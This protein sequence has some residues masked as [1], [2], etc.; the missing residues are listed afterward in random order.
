MNRIIAIKAR[1]TYGLRILLVTG[2]GTSVT[3]SEAALLNLAD[4]PPYLITAVEP[5]V[6]LTFDDS[7]SMNWSYL[8]DTVSGLSN[9]NR[10][11]SSEINKVYFDPNIVYDTPVMEDGVTLLNAASPT[12]FT[13]AY[14]NGFAGGTRDNLATNYRPSWNSL[15]PSV[16]CN[17]AG[18]PGAA[19]YYTYNTVCGNVNSDACYTLVRPIPAAQQQNFAN[20]YS[21]YRNRNSMAKSAAGRAFA[22]FG[23]NVRVAGHHLDGSGGSTGSGALKFPGTF[24]AG[25]LKPFTGTNRTD[26][27]TSLYDSPASS[28]TPLR[29]AM[30]RA[31][32]YLMTDDPYLDTPGTAFNATTNPERSCRQNFHVFMTDGYWNSPTGPIPGSGTPG[33]IVTGNQ[34]DTAQTLPPPD[35]VSYTAGRAPYSDAWSGTLADAAFYYWATDLRSGLTNNVPTH[36]TVG[37]PATDYWNPVN[38]PANWQHMENFTIGLGIPGT[39]TKDTAT[40]N[41]LV[42]G[43]TAWPDPITNSLG[44]RIDD[45]W[46]AA[47]NSRGQYFSASN[48]T[49][50]VTAFTEV[51]NNVADRISSSSS[52]A[53]NSGSLTGSNFAYQARFDSSNWTGQLLAYPI[54][55]S[56]GVLSTTASWDAAV[57]LNG[58]HYDT[59]RQII[60]YKPSTRAGIP[61]RTGSLDTS[62]STA[63]NYNPITATTDTQGSA[64]LNYL[65]GDASNEG[66]GNNY[67]VRNRLCGLVACPPGTNTGVLGDIIN[68]GPLY[69]GPPPFDYPTSLE[70]PSYPAF[71]DLA[72]NKNRTPIIYAGANDGML[73]GFNASTGLEMFAYVPDKV[74]N[75][76]SRLAHTPYTHKYFVDGGTM[77]G[78]VVIGGVWRSILV[79]TLRKGGQGIFAIDITDPSSFTEANASNLVLWEFTDANDADLGYTYSEPSIVRMHN[80]KWAVI[81]G[82]GYN[83]SEADGM[84]STTGR[85]VLYI[86]VVSDYTSAGGWILGTNYFK[87]TTG[88]GSVTTPNGLASP[89]AVDN[90]GDY[91]VDQ[92]YAGDLQGNMWRFDVT[93]STASTWDNPGNRKLVY[94]AGSQQPITVRPRIRKHPAGQP[95]N[96]VY[97]GT[98]KYLETSDSSIV[99]ATTQTFYGVW[100]ESGVA[101]PV[102]TNLLEQTVLGSSTAQFRVTSNNPMIWR[103]GS[104]VPSPSYIGWYLDLPT[105]GERQVTNPIL[106]GGRI[107]FTTVIPSDDPCSVGGDG[108]LMELNASSG[109]RLDNT[110]FD[111]NNDGVFS[112]L[113]LI[114]GLPASGQ[115]L[116]GI[117]SSPTIQ[118]GGNPAVSPA[119]TTARCR[120]QKL[121]S[122]SSGGIASPIENPDTCSYCRASWRQIR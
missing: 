63:L 122:G 48:P 116:T 83:N 103:A 78:D 98:G 85:A 16:T 39:L 47:I 120:E 84:A 1:L 50:L 75:N 70:T 5:N 68:S 37:T 27:F 20:W 104:P 73:H 76:L 88:V 31:G 74:Y 49:E 92:I 35:S 24:S 11:C 25:A 99:G 119:C 52:V 107:I 118:T 43:S 86:L 96:M 112:G 77:A 69:V 7:G 121:I 36:F 3:V 26:F 33:P 53:L 12:L 21:Y 82:N 64:R 41:N 46:H 93:S 81:F 109:G 102:K 61:F 94:A 80:G 87:L 6:L 19:F 32:D 51:V 30:K 29:E 110:P 14:R 10:G 101:N 90:D 97:F 55:A 8:P 60:T 13:S 34:D 108:W 91:I 89:A 111:V 59:G 38:D 72:A 22:R 66:T 40:Y 95:G 28:W 113:D 15:T 2:L 9:T 18:V 17:T 114:G 58:Q 42:A 44:Q 115:K 106:R 45:L 67:R 65:R 4:S 117:P 62:Q 79:G 23:T 57:L 56:T 54:S 105:T 71:R 100:D